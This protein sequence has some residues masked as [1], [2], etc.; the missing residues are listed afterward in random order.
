[1]SPLKKIKFPAHELAMMMTIA[2]RF[3]PTL[4]QE[5]DKIIAAQKARGAKLDTG[6]LIERAK[7]L[8]PIVVP[9]FISAFR[10]ADELATAMECRCYNGGKN[11]TKMKQLKLTKVDFIA[12]GLSMIYILGILTIK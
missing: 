3:I 4:I 1:M 12:I 5:T 8:I 6:K 10:A 7:S 2:L 9:L 11:R